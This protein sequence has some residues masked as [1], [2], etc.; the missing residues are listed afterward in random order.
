MECQEGVKKPLFT[1]GII[2][3]SGLFAFACFLVF[4]VRCVVSLIY[5]LSCQMQLLVDHAYCM[6][7]LREFLDLY[8]I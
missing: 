4:L 1:R 5:P 6:G 8:I 7:G 3:E 2:C